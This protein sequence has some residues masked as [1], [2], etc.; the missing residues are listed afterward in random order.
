[1]DLINSIIAGIIATAILGGGVAYKVISKKRNSGII[2][3]EG[4]NQVALQR[5]K[6]NSI[7]IGGDS[8]DKENGSKSK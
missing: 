1:M 7:N 5:S 3:R 4:T 6:N 8:A 2:Q